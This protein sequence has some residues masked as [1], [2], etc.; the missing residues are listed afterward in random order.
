MSQSPISAGEASPAY[1][2]SWD[3]LSAM[4]SQGGSFSGRERNCCFLNTRDDRFADVSAATGLDLDDDGRGAA[5]VDWDDDGDLDLWLT[6]R[7]GP[8]VRFMR[9]DTGAGNNF[10]ALK[11]EGTHCNRDAIGARV[12]LVL[13]GTPPLRRIKTLH[14]GD[15]FVSQSSKSIHFGLGPSPRIQK[16]IIYW[17]GSREGET[18]SDL[19]PNGRYKMV[20]GTGRA[21]S[22]AVRSLPVALKPSTPIVPPSTRQARLIL[23]R[24]RPFPA[25][26]Q[27]KVAVQP[28]SSHSHVGPMLVNLWAS[29]CQPCVVELREWSERYDALRTAGLTILALNTDTLVPAETGDQPASDELFRGAPLPFPTG[30]ASKELVGELTELHHQIVYPQR[31]LPLPCSFLVDRNGMV[32]AIYTGRVS[33]AQ[34]LEDQQLLD[35]TPEKLS[36]LAFPFVSQ[37]GIDLFDITPIGLARAYHEGGYFEDAKA[38]VDGYVRNL[39]AQAS[40]EKTEARRQ[41]SRLVECYRL[42]AA[43]AQ[44]QRDADAEV[45]ACRQLVRLLPENLQA[46]VALAVAHWR[47]DQVEQSELALD[48]ARKL[49]PNHPATLNMLGKARMAMRQPRQAIQRYLEAIELAP[50]DMEIRFNMAFALKHAGQAAEAIE[51]YR[52]VLEK[53]PTSIE[54]LNN[55]AWIL[56]T[57]PDP[58][59]R[60]AAEALELA[61]RVCQATNY[62]APEYLDT[63]AAALAEAGQFGEAVQTAHKAAELARSGGQD[64]LARQLAQRL[65]RYE[66]KKP[67]RQ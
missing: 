62:D 25:L 43:I 49:A 52:L 66:S 59:L 11:L 20:Q 60:S 15:G 64:E 23:T 4:I 47:H 1:L 61:K 19:E 58:E 34:L 67:Y 41:G 27:H 55:L 46:R 40:D 5:L 28:Q 39:S 12:E 24:R 6:N 54:T 65:K 32:A 3:A 35:A 31:P 33:V 10:L 7:T 18:F 57:H 51:Q 56:A 37:D 50:D 22:M 36:Q 13:D 21:I 38:T 2:K 8:R 63:L 45:Q 14:A 42:L 30:M 44:D 9:N 26:Q 17:P 53:Q 29:W 48:E 16:V